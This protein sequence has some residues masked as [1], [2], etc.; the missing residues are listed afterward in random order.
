MRNNT[1]SLEVIFPVVPCVSVSFELP[2]ARSKI[3]DV[4]TEPVIVELRW[5][6]PNAVM[7]DWAM[8]AGGVSVECV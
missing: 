2:A 7:T 4:D 1:E 8:T 5:L 6:P 3:R